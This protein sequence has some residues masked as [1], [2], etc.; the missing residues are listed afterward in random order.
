V[1]GQAAWFDVRVR[2]RKCTADELPVAARAASHGGG[3]AQRATALRWPE[4][5]RKERR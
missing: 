4:W 2:L 1:T 3:R 5:L